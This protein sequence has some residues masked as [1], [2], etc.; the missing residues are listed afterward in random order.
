[1]GRPVVVSDHGGGREQVLPE[2]TGFLYPPTDPAA[3]AAALAK[4]LDLSAAA[5]ARLGETAIAHARAQF[6]KT[7][8]CAKTLAVYR[9][10]IGEWAPAAAAPA[11]AGAPA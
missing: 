7:A 10:L 4:A 1:M 6:S 11:N 9:E 2:E 8:M 5:R 3:L